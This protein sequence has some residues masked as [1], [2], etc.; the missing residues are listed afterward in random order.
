MSLQKLHGLRVMHLDAGNM[1]WEIT[2]NHYC[3]E[4]DNLRLL[5]DIK[6]FFILYFFIDNKLVHEDGTL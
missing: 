5:F 2:L 4:H 6:L 3:R 1:N